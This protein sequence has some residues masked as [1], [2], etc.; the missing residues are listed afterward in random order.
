[1]C[2]CGI[3]HALHR[4]FSEAG[5]Y[6]PEEVEL[7]SRKLDRLT[8][9]LSSAQQ[10]MMTTLTEV[11]AE[12]TQSARDTFSRF[13]NTYAQCVCVRVCVV[14]FAMCT[15]IL[16]HMNRYQLYWTDACYMEDVKRSLTNLQLSIRSVVADSNSQAS[17]LHDVITRLQS[18]LMEVSVCVCVCVCVVCES[19]HNTLHCSMETPPPSWRSCLL[20][21]TFAPSILPTC[22][23]ERRCSREGGWGARERE[24]QPSQY[25]QSTSHGVSESECRST[26]DIIHCMCS[27]M[28][29]HKSRQQSSVHSLSTTCNT[30][31]GQG[32]H[33]TYHLTCTYCTC[34]DM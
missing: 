8:A 6:C 17:N 10:Q 30:A 5:N 11:T 18:G 20:W 26:T 15:C 32:T 33:I 16:S 7:F 24:G 23:A 12:H 14:L 22:T 34:D 31:S 3:S 13:Q 27:I 9:K 2:V 4:L 28:Q 25:L 21:L 29:S 19:L 1:M